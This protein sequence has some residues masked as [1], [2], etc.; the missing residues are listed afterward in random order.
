MTT[1]KA[2]EGLLLIVKSQ[3]SLRKFFLE[4]NRIDYFNLSKKKQRS[5][6]HLNKGN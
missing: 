3:E 5:I 4:V 1:F 6:Y 2:H